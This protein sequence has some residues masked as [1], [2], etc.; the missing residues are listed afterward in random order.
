M[1]VRG[2]KLLQ[3]LP[4]IPRWIYARWMV[5]SGNGRIYVENKSENS[6]IIQDP[7]NGLT[8]VV[9]K[10]GADVIQ[11]SLTSIDM[12]V[13]IIGFKNNYRYIE[14]ELKEFERST[15]YLYTLSEEKPKYSYTDASVRF[16]MKNDIQ[17][18]R[19]IPDVLRKELVDALLQSPVAAGLIEDKPVSFCY[20]AAMTETLW[21]ISID[22]LKPYRN[23]GYAGHTVGFMIEHMM[24][25]GK[26]P[27]W[28]AEESNRASVHLAKKLGFKPVDKLYLFNKSQE[29]PN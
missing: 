27:V 29:S 4:D 5:L 15:A 6:F 1:G 12:P 19:H 3:L 14:N 22:T 23:K 28:G 24:T 21:D 10:P 16:M 26:R 17:A 9:G 8:C 11:K 13:R 20:A 18:A 7:N 25:K 2:A